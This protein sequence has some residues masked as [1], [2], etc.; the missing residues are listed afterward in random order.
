MSNEDALSYAVRLLEGKAVMTK[1]GCRM[2][3]NA[4]IRLTRPAQPGQ[5]NGE[6]PSNEGVAAWAAR[7]EGDTPETEVAEKEIT[8]AQKHEPE[9]WY[10][11]GSDERHALKLSGWIDIHGPGYQ[12]GIVK[13]CAED[14]HNNHDGWE[15]SWPRE[16]TIFALENQ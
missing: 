7:G 6:M 1:A 10:S 3:A 5:C 14:F 4:V 12:A 13:Q 11:T 2:L 16:F 9:I 8:M 15:C